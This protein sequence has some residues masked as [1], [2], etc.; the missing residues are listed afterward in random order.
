ME[1]S[2]ETVTLPLDTKNKQSEYQKR[3]KKTT[4]ELYES[5]LI[6]VKLN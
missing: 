3:R 5:I 4:V 1:S 2:S 6:P